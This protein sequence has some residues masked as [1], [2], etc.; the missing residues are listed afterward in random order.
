MKFPDLEQSKQFLIDSY[1]SQML[2][3]LKSKMKL[4]KPKEAPG[5][6][7]KKKP[8]K[9]AVLPIKRRTSLR[10][11]GIRDK[12]QIQERL[13]KISDR[14]RISARIAALPVVVYGKGLS[15]PKPTTTIYGSLFSGQVF[16]QFQ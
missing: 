1:E 11:A 3:K 2:S 5:V 13:T 8:R 14:R 15:P 7:P 12:G 6:V 10:L 9:I 4:K 16:N